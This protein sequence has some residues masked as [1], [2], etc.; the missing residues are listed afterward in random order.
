MAFLLKPLEILFWAFTYPETNK[1]AWN[2][3]DQAEVIVLQDF[4]W[5]S[6]LI[7]WKDLLL[8]LEGEKVQLPSPKNQFPTEVTAISIFATSKKE[9]ELVGKHNTLDDRERELID[10]G[11]NIFT[12]THRIKHIDQNV[13]TPCL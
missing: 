3:A 6:E 1:Y 9:I 12:F 11:L 4:R 2:G 13:I 10:V 5:N 7:C 8:L